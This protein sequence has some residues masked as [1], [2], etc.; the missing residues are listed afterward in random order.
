MSAYALV[1]FDV[2][3]CTAIVDSKKL[4]LDGK[5]LVN[6]QHGHMKLHREKLK[7]EIL[8]LSDSKKVLN[9]F[10]DEWSTSHRSIALDNE[11]KKRKN[12]PDGYLSVWPHDMDD[13]V[14][15]SD[16]HVNE[17]TPAVQQ[18]KP[19]D[20]PV[21]KPDKSESRKGAPKKTLEKSTKSSKKKANEKTGS[22]RRKI[23]VLY[24][25]SGDFSTDVSEPQ[26][27][28]CY[29]EELSAD[30]QDLVQQQI[31][32]H[33]NGRKSIAS[34]TDEI[35]MLGPDDVLSTAAPNELKLIMKLLHKMEQS[36]K[37]QKNR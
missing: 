23:T 15:A 2:D 20:V 9:E 32:Q 5:T 13:T 1:L 8:Q 31:H 16:N 19:K 30:E 4:C 7:V 12:R 34:Q 10:E 36:Q 35:V 14:P 26:R 25:G 22:K 3:G 6:G 28:P 18:P 21:Q 37:R 29:L 11:K 24:E 27:A 33:Q 17:E